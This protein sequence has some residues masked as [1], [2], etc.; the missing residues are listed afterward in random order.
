MNKDRAAGETSRPFAIPSRCCHALVAPFEQFASQ[1]QGSSCST[2]GIVPA[3]GPCKQLS[4]CRKVREVVP[5]R[6][7]PIHGQVGAKRPG[8][9]PTCGLCVVRIMDGPINGEW[10]GAYVAQVLVPELRPG[11]VVIMDNLSSHERALIRELIEA[12]GASLRYL[13]SYSADSG[14]IE[15]AFARLKAMLR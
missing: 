6:P 2:A 11:D 14:P 4:C 12:A 10:F 9:L 8:F 15:K 5:S 3:I 13:A 7:D 1:D